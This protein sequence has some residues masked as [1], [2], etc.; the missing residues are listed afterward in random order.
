MWLSQTLAAA[1]WTSFF[2]KFPCIFPKLEIANAITGIFFRSS[3]N[4]MNSC[5]IDQY[6]INRWNHTAL[7]V[8]K[9]CTDF[10]YYLNKV[11]LRI[12]QSARQTSGMA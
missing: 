12:F 1:R 6:T 10:G 5:N 9:T 2:D 7:L 3:A 11:D 8:Y 4:C